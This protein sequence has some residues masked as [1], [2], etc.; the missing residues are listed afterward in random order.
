M[1]PE[2]LAFNTFYER[3]KTYIYIEEQVRVHV[4]H[5]Q[6][7]RVLV[8]GHEAAVQQDAEESGPRYKDESVRGEPAVP[9]VMAVLQP[10]VS[11]GCTEARRSGN[12]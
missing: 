6:L 5:Q 1:E 3:F 11:V 7:L 4:R 8:G 12:T 2:I 9:R 10:S